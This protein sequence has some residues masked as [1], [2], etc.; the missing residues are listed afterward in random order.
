MLP[1]QVAQVVADEMEDRLDEMSWRMGALEA[2]LYTRTSGNH[3]EK[4]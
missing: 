3:Q 2:K 1:F 4:P